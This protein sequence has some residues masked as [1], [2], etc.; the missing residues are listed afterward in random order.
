MLTKL[1]IFCN[2]RLHI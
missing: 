1:D 2:G